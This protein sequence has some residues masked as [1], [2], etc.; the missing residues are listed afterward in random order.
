MDSRDK[1]FI[2]SDGWWV[3]DSNAWFVCGMS[4]ELF[5]V[6]FNTGRCE[7]VTDIPERGKSTYRL[8]QFCL[9]YDRDIFC[10]PGIGQS[11]WVFNLDHENFTQLSIDKPEGLQVASQFR[12]WED[13]LFIVL[14]NW[15][16][17]MEV[18]IK[19]KKIK[20]YYTVCE[21]D[22]IRK[23][24]FVD[25]YIYMVSSK[26]C[27]VYEFDLVTKKTRTYI[28][29]EVEKKLSAICFDGVKF[30]LSGY[31]KEVYIWE[32]ENNKFTTIDNFPSDFN[33]NDVGEN[34]EDPK[35]PIFKY[36][37]A[38]GGYI[39]FIPIR[40]D[41]IIYADKESGALSA[42]EIYDED[43][44][45][46]SIAL[47][48]MWA[49]ANYLLEYVKDDRYIGLFSAKSGRIFEIDAQ[50][51]HYQWKEYYLKDKYFFQRGGIYNELYV[52]GIDDKLYKE[53]Y[54]RQASKRRKINNLYNNTTG[55]E[56]YRKTIE[57]EKQL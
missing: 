17:V 1:T 20:N 23:S 16:R 36:A 48:Q 24:V 42:F 9:K 8:T 52:E 54:H 7:E 25:N 27:G 55:K 26:N 12:I 21:G 29:T 41:K 6:D 32:K 14:E 44:T 34:I 28:F 40:A 57:G 2:W 47:R 56:I 4:N 45:E 53:A 49:I 18:D 43:E 51:L 3:E 10:I 38:V 50:E 31:Q 46:E 35:L 11:I 30:W 5:Y 22:N 33:M 37:V 19:Q 13:T 39:W 15:N